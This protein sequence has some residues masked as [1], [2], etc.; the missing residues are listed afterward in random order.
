MM[1][2]PSVFGRTATGT[3]VVEAPAEGMAVR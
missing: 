1:Y 2:R 3:L